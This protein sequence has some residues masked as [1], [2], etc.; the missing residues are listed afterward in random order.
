MWKRDAR[1]MLGNGANGKGCEL[2]IGGGN[3][4]ATSCMSLSS[5]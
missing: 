2:C 1:L 3:E 4:F 5:E